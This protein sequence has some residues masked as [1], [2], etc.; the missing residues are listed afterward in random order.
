MVTAN[1][2]TVLNCCLIGQSCQVIPGYIGLP[3]VKSFELLDQYGY[4]STC[5]VEMSL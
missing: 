5:K 4:I 2:V 3:K 1:T